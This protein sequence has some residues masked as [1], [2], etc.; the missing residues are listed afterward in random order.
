MLRRYT[1]KVFV[2]YDEV[3]PYDEFDPRPFPS[4]PAMSIGV[5]LR[6]VSAVQDD[7]DEAMARAG[8]VAVD[9]PVERSFRLP[10]VDLAPDSGSLQWKAVEAAARRFA[11]DVVLA[12][13]PWGF[14][15][16]ARASV[17]AEFASLSTLLV[18]DG[19]FVRCSVLPVIFE[20]AVV[21]VFP[22]WR[23]PPAEPMPALE[24]AID[25]LTDPS[26]PPPVL[27]EGDDVCVV[28]FAELTADPATRLPCSHVF[29]RRCIARWLRSSCACPLCRFA[30][31]H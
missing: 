21:S 16:P 11:S 6:V 10:C 15:A 4:W 1:H 27:A 17:A 13:A 18:Y 29:H 22:A 23:P 9:P 7:E 30:M 26:Q 31:P 25:G 28:C 12:A 5:K 3:R 24:S 19:R 8:G 2:D 20:I 14:T